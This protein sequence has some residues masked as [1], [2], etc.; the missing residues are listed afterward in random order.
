MKKLWWMV[1]YV[2]CKGLC[3]ASCTNVPLF[4]TE[5][6][7]LIE[8]HKAVI[9]PALVPAMESTVMVP[10]LGAGE[11]C[12]FLDTNGR[13]S[14]YNDRPSVCREFGHKALTLDCGYDCKAKIP[15][16][17]AQTLYIMAEH[18]KISNFAVTPMT[19]LTNE[20]AR[21]VDEMEVEVEC[22]EEEAE[23][24]NQ[25][26]DDKSKKVIDWTA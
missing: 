1:P 6:L 13:C 18:L 20:M 15:L 19:D 11:P 22:T 4:P 8:K 21:Q 23:K 16:T 12:Q 3:Q 7:Y 2:H 10:V 5:A 9:L 17:E 24:I 14:I 25:M 26:H